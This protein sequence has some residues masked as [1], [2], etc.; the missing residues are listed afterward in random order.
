MLENLTNA[1]QTVQQFIN[2]SNLGENLTKLVQNSSNSDQ[3]QINSTLENLNN[4][5]KS[6]SSTTNNNNN[7]PTELSNKKKEVNTTNNLKRQQMLAPDYNPT[8]IK[9]LKK[10]KQESIN[11]NDDDDS[12]DGE[13]T[14]NNKRRKKTS[15]SNSDNKTNNPIVITNKTSRSESASSLIRNNKNDN[16]SSKTSS[17]IKSETSK[18]DL[19]TFS[20][21]TLSQQVLKRYE[22]L[23]KTPP[24]SASI[25]EAK[26]K[27]VQNQLNGSNALQAS[28]IQENQTLKVP[29]LL[30]DSSGSNKV[31]LVM[32][33]RYL[34][35]IFEN[36]KSE[37]SNLEKACEKAA[38]Q[39][40]SIYDRAKNKTI[41]T[42]LVANLIR[43]MRNSTNTA[44]PQKNSSNIEQASSS[45]S[46]EAMLSGPKANRVS[47]SINR[48]KQLEVKDL[49]GFFL[50]LKLKVEL[51]I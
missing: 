15:E 25:N 49:S 24:T 23:N 17:E 4:A 37:S 32:R 13:I 51:R 8:P 20:K 26:L 18:T 47:Y 50:S 2:S 43:S 34:K 1:L 39:E 21:L 16:S 5:L 46:H 38:E 19:I 10:V 22:M 28:K 12:N 29:H 9:E 7:I 27:K 31:P 35:V 44:S 40:K 42:N 33:Q 45:Y 41:Y 48:T 30:M 11:D 3:T 36:G 6:I 14:N